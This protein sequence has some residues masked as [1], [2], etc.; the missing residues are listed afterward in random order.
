M[1]IDRKFRTSK[2][3]GLLSKGG[4]L[5]AFDNAF[6]ESLRINDEEFDFIAAN[7][8]DKEIEILTTHPENYE[9]RKYFLIVL[10][11]VLNRKI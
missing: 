10:Q 2:D 11:E 3:L 5:D 1:R 8:A 9:S 7:A 4:I 6:K